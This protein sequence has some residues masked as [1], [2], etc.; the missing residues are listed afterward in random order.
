MHTVCRLPSSHEY[1]QASLPVPCFVTPRALDDLS[2]CS[3]DN[4]RAKARS[5]IGR[6]RCGR[7]SCISLVTCGLEFPTKISEKVARGQQ[8]RP[9]RHKCNCR[10]SRIARVIASRASTPSLRSRIGMELRSRQQHGVSLRSR[11]KPWPCSNIIRPMQSTSMATAFLRS[12]ARSVRPNLTAAL[13]TLIFPKHS[14]LAT[15][16]WRLGMSTI[17]AKAQTTST[18]MAAPLLFNGMPGGI[19]TL[20]CAAEAQAAA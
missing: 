2:L 3:L 15:L 8:S 19:L 5:T 18:S 14:A 12:G 20:P 10:N 11:T 16:G 6:S 1:D 4:P 9:K 13:L 17:L 7:G